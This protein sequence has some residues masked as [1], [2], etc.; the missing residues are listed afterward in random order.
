MLTLVMLAGEPFQPVHTIRVNSKH[1]PSS[2]YI[3]HI[4]LHCNYKRMPL[5]PCYQHCLC[6]DAALV[7]D[8]KQ[9]HALQIP[10]ADRGIY[11][12]LVLC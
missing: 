10:A 6:V 2:A 1:A 12:P 3:V 7:V 8:P 9:D 11:K 4:C 5:W